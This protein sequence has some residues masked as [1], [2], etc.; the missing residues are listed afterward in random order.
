MRSERMEWLAMG[1][2]AGGG[3]RLRLPHAGAGAA[4]S[5][6]T[7]TERAAVVNGV[8]RNL[9]PIRRRPLCGSLQAKRSAV[10]VG[11]P[12]GGARHAPAPLGPERRS[13]ARCT[14]LTP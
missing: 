14:S 6:L 8:V 10:T 1:A 5:T 9:A 12:G 2:K 4:H 7:D 3:R 11:V 13:V